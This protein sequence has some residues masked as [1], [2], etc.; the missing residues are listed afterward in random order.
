MANNEYYDN[1]TK[2]LQDATAKRE[3]AYGRLDAL[4]A[5]RQA[6]SNQMYQMVEKQRLAGEADLETQRLADVQKKHDDKINWMD[7]ASKGAAMGGGVGGA[8][9]AL[10][11]GIIGTVKGQAEAV[12]QRRRDGDGFFKAF[13]KTHFDTPFKVGGYG[14][15]LKFNDDSYAVAGMLGKKWMDKRAD[16][17]K[18]A[19]GAEELNTPTQKPLTLEELQLNRPEISGLSSEPSASDYAQLQEPSF[20]YRRGKKM[21]G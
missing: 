11:G 9:G 7:D 18:E 5:K 19:V 3:E 20:T 2:A 6:W 17:N 13:A 15:G 14:G 1:A 8:W 21:G 4:K 12:Q 10:A 16:N